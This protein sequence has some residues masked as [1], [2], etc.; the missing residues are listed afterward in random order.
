M[1]SPFDSF[2]D[3]GLTARLREVEARQRSLDAERAELLW[4]WDRRR[5]WADD[6]SLSAAARLA[7]ETG[8]TGAEARSRIRT[9]QVLGS[10]PHTAAALAELGWAKARLLAG[11]VNERTIDSFVEHEALLVKHALEMTADQLALLLRSW[12]QLVDPEGANAVADA[13]HDGSYLHLSQS[14]DGVGFLN[15]RLDPESFAIVKGVLDQLAEVLYRAERNDAMVARVGGDEPDPPR[16]PPERRADAL[17]EMARRAAAT[18]AAARDGATVTPARPLVL[19]HIDV[20]D[21]GTVLARLADGTPISTADATRLACDAAVARVLSKN[22]SVPLDLGRTTRDPS[23]AQRRAL[24][25]LWSTCAF[26][27]CDRPFAWCQLHHVIH[28]D[29]GGPTDIHLLVPQ[30]VGHH[31]RHHQGVFRIHRRADGAF[32]FTRRDGTLIGITTPDLSL[33]HGVL[34]GLPR[35]G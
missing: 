13:Q 18:T 27:G 30:C 35:A 2:D 23:D 28:W 33:V 21:A 20:D 17:V 11:A 5:A 1:S 12:K 4:A 8:V 15:G 7:R 25:A 14:I 26:P 31:R 6:G 3:A 29:D 32:V 19:V 24:S 10:M 34:R 22:G 9:V 16:S